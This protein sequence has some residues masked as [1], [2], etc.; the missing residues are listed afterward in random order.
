MLSAISTKL[1]FMWSKI[2]SYCR[3]V[4]LGQF[5]YALQKIFSLTWPFNFRP[6]ISVENQRYFST[7]TSTI[8]FFFSFFCQSQLAHSIMGNFATKKTVVLTAQWSSCLL[9]FVSGMT[10]LLCYS[11]PFPYGD[12][13]WPI[14]TYGSLRHKKKAGTNHSRHFISLFS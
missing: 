3:C 12:F 1:I 9:F 8:F 11:Q 6:F 13:V 5:L 4:M 2:W 7:S 14:A 10:Q